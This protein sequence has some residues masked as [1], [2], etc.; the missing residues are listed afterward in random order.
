[1]YSR[2]V[3]KVFYFG[4]DLFVRTF[5]KNPS[6]HTNGCGRWQKIDEIVKKHETSSTHLSA[7]CECIE[8][9]KRLD[10]NAGIDKE[11]QRILDESTKNWR[12]VLERLMAVCLAEDDLPFRDSSDKLFSSKNGNFMSPIY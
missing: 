2:K 4:C 10:L 9:K 1:M 3:D 7:S 11:R 8:A 5:T 6:L 12:E